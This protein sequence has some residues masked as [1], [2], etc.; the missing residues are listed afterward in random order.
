PPRDRYE[1]NDD[2]GDRAYRMSGASRRLFATVDYWNDQDDVYAV[3]IERGQRM[4]VG[5]TGAD[6]SVDLNLALWRPNTPSIESI[7]S[8]GHR[9]K[10]SARP[11]GRQYFSHR[12]RATGWYFV[13]VRASSPGTTRYRLTVVKG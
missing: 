9:I 4:Y 13:Q 2:T 12:A 5:L 1:A 3:Q 7:H 6:P 10:I 8:V 11:G